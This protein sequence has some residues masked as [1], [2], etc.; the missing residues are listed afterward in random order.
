M[1]YKILIAEDDI[2]YRYAISETIPWEEHGFEI[3]GEAI[4]GRQAMEFLAENQVDIVLT[5]MSMPLMNGVELTRRV[6]EQYPEIIVVALSAYDDFQFVKESLKY[7]ARDY[8][9]KQEMDASGIIR[10][11]KEACREREMKHHDLLAKQQLQQELQAL[12]RGEI[13]VSE[14]MKAYLRSIVK[15]K[16]FFLLWFDNKE[17]GISALWPELLKE[18]RVLHQF[19]DPEGNCLILYELSSN[20][21]KAKYMAEIGS[22]VGKMDMV[23][24][25]QVQILASK[26]IYD[27]ESL[28]AA[29]RQLVALR[30]IKQYIDQQRHLLYY[31]YESE[32]KNR[33]KSYHYSMPQEINLASFNQVKLQMQEMADQLRLYLP[34]Q[35]HLNKNFLSFCSRMFKAQTHKDW[36]GA[37][38]YHGLCRCT[39]LSG[40]IDYTLDFLY[41]EW[42]QGGAGYCGNSPEV[43][44]ALRYI[45][46]HYTQEISLTAVANHVG[47]SENYFSNLFKAEMSENLTHYINRLRI[48]QAKHLMDTTNMRMYEIS[49]AVGYKNATY[50]STMFKKITNTGVSDYRRKIL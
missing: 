11:L 16:C 30:E 17:S 20:M 44:Q 15:E 21:G 25:Q 10:S 28:E 12:L 46:Q 47:L 29:V 31:D 2:N 43:R 9:L 24:P 38:Y 50:F 7:G 49:E 1:T 5:D 40:R 34:D 23:L 33:N 27:V 42:M 45:Y 35:E 39:S 26:E 22:I 19:A 48:E 8:I 4:H 6:K 37:A 32:I 41:R 14:T 3:V 36:D 18:P 13:S